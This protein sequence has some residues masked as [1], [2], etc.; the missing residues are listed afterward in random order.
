METSSWE[1]IVTDVRIL[2]RGTSLLYAPRAPAEPNAAKRV[3]GA[4]AP[5]RR[6]PRKRVRQERHGERGPAPRERASA[7]SAAASSLTPPDVRRERR[8]GRQAQ[9]QPIVRPRFC[10]SSQAMSGLKYSAMA[11]VERSSPVASRRTFRQSSVAPFSMI[12]FRKAPTS[13]LSA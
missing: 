7:P 6:A 9:S 13:L 10:F 12:P 8:A 3:P 2:P 1:R 4:C 11:R 5:R